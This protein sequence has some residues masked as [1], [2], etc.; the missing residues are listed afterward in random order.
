MTIDD[1]ARE[2]RDLR[3]MNQLLKEQLTKALEVIVEIRNAGERPE[4][5][6]RVAQPCLIEF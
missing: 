5:R 3:R 6:G 2:N 4:H 1:Y